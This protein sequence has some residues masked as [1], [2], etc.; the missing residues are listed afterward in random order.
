MDTFS[1]RAAL[2]PRNFPAC[3]RAA[4]CYN[5]L[6]AFRVLKWRNWQTR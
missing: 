4:L 6:S 5:F 2:G 3:L 1:G